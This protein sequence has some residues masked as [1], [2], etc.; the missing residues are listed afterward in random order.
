MG[1][2]EVTSFISPHQLAYK[3]SITLPGSFLSYNFRTFNSCYLLGSQNLRLVMCS[4]VSLYK[5]SSFSFSFTTQCDIFCQGLVVAP[6]CCWFWC[7]CW[8]RCCWTNICS[9]PLNFTVPTAHSPAAIAL[10]ENIQTSSSQLCKILRLDLEPENSLS[11]WSLQSSK[12]SLPLN[13]RTLS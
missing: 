13:S 6:C 8:L 4:H 1:T 7:H 5:A 9:S 11:E 12:L 2:T 10:Y 3:N